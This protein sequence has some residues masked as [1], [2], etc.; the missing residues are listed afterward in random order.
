MGTSFP[1]AL[2]VTNDSIALGAIKAFKEFGICV[3]GDISIGGVDAIP[4]SAIADP[5]LTTLNVSCKDIGIWTVRLLYDRIQCPSSPIMKIQVG[6]SL[7]E[8]G[9]TCAYRGG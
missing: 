1:P 8:R 4:F 9:S 6:A 3:P 7:V 5:P 2:I